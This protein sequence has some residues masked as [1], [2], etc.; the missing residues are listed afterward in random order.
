MPALSDTMNVGRL[1]RWLK[2]PGDPVTKGETPAP[3]VVALT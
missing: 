2:Q 3:S 1:T